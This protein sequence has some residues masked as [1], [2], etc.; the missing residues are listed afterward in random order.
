MGLAAHVGCR[1][2]VDTDRVEGA[3]SK[4]DQKREERMEGV[5]DV[6]DDLDESDKEG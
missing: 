2:S 6:H 3:K 4:V 5:S 1:L